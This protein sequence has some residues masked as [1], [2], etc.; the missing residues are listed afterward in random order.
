MALTLLCQTQ[1]STRRPA[2]TFLAGAAVSCAIAP[3]K[4][5]QL[6]SNMKR[7]KIKSAQ[8]QRT[9]AARA[10]STLQSSKP[11]LA[12]PL[13]GA[14]GNV[15]NRLAAA[16]RAALRLPAILHIV[17]SP[18]PAADLPRRILPERSFCRLQRCTPLSSPR[19]RQPMAEI[20]LRRDSVA[21]KGTE[22][23]AD[24]SSTPSSVRF[25]RKISNRSAS[26]RRDNRHLHRIGLM[27]NP[28]KR[29]EPRADNSSTPSS[30]LLSTPTLAGTTD[31][32]NRAITS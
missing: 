6:L 8:Q 14:V 21:Q 2:L 22:P 31:R 29:T 16:T 27:P 9:S 4:S 32:M 28:L 7:I 20:Q 13:V 1:P 18:Q 3:V 11:I 10:G 23:R 25:F 12:G 24:N 19:N 15:V 5:V 17:H 30:V 26:S